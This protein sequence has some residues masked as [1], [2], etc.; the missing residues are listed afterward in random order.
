MC[1]RDRGID[2]HKKKTGKVFDEDRQEWK[3][4]WGKRAK[5]DKEKYDWLRE[6][7]PGYVAKEDGGDPFLDDRREK[8]VR[9][10]KEL[11][12]IHISEPTRL[13]SISYAVFCLKKKK[14]R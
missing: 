14:N 6:V 7:K 3:D 12:L 9:M 5:E 2:I 10:D 4:K 8:K 11:S 13:L 1:I